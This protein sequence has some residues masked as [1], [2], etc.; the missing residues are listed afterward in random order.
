MTVGKK[1]L[2]GYAVVLMGLAF[3]V[4]MAIHALQTT[5]DAYTS[6]LEKES[7]A[8]VLATELGREVR[9]QSAQYRG[10]LLYPEQQS[11][12]TVD[13]RNSHQEV[14]GLL[15]KLRAM[16]HDEE[17][18]RLLDEISDLQRAF[19][20]HQEQGLSLLQQGKREEALAVGRDALVSSSRLR[21]KHEQYIAYERRQLADGRMQVERRL[22]LILTWLASVSIGVLVGGI[23]LG[24]LLTRG[25][26][27]TLNETIMRLASSSNEILATTTQVASG[28][29]E[30]ATA[31]NE[32]MATVE[33]VK[34]TAQLASQKARHVSDSAAKAAEISQAGRASVEQAIALMQR[35]EAQMGSMG[36]SIVRL[37][38]QSQAIGEITATVNDLA[39][40]SNL[41][42]VNAAIEAA[43]AGEQGKGF[44]VVAQE[45]RS[46]AEQS[47]QATAQVRAILGDIQ[48]A[49]TAAVMATEQGSNTVATGVRQSGE[50]GE[51]IRRLAERV[52]EAA[53]AATQIAASSQ[54]QIVGMEQIA[55][56]IEHISQASM[57]NVTGTRQAESAA[58]DL[59]EL[60]RRLEQMV[61]G[62]RS[63]RA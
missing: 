53:Q 42:A 5:E 10:L 60:G 61:G 11:R 43:R 62:A 14:D 6:F 9:D 59:H 40:Q 7:R 15:Q 27:R 22:G 21:D 31:V 28:A 47:K 24:L 17:G 52:T 32:T 41:L 20:A 34:Q 23:A 29:T 39:E 3:V 58:H 35:I 1:I 63:A 57:Q 18:I 50:A 13:L 38:E 19:R 56:A 44:A 55:Q 12:L 49:T 8:L 33:E 51:A 36:Q 26:T 46:L 37:S 30:T 25:I 2:G 54:Q 16:P 4:A 48:K 45:V